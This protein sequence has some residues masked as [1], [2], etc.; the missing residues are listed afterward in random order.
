M[1]K[2]NLKFGIW[3][4]EC[5]SQC[6]KFFL[7]AV[8]FLVSSPFAFGQKNKKYSEDL[9]KYRPRVELVEVVIQKDS[10]PPQTAVQD[11]TPRYTVNAKVDAILDSIDRFNLTRRYIEGFTIQI[12]SGQKKMDAMDAKTKM[13][14]E[15]PDMS[16]NLQYQQPKFKVTVGKYFSRLEAQRDLMVLRRKFPNAILVPERILIR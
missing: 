11:I 6:S 5:G 14:E 12:Y 4:M 3:L 7:M 10:L 1:K 15:L 16:A 2:K 8:L 9:S 13:Q